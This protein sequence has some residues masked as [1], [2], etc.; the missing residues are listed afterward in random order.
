MRKQI[1]LF[2]LIFLAGCSFG[3]EVE[4]VEPEPAADMEPKSNGEQMGDTDAVKERITP[5]PSLPNLGPAPEVDNEVW[6][7]TDQP[8][9]LAKLRGQ[10]VLLEMWTFG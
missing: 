8:L 10:V 7:N 4:G 9:S 3:L 1:L 2:S 5:S 6:L